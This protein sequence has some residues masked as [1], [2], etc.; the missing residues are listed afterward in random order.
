MRNLTLLDNVDA[1]TQQISEPVN[2][3]HRVEWKIYINSTG[4]DGTPQIYI[5]D[6]SSGSKCIDPAYNWNPI[7]NRC[8]EL[9]YFPIDDDLITI[10][11]KD[12][13]A[14]WF[15]VRVEANDN[16]TGTID[17]RITY[18]TFP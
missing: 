14:S 8:D 1:N 5:E 10:E 12:F 13:K 3:D 11:K 18:K 17:V 2:F 7:C 9:D 6:N 4:L 16:T 15:R